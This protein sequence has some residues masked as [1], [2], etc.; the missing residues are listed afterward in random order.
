MPKPSCV[1]RSGLLTACAAVVAVFP[2]RA[3]PGGY[4]GITSDYVLRG[5]SQSDGKAAWQG[6]LHWDFPAGLT[7]GVWTSQV[8][9]EPHSESVELDGYLQWR[10]TLSPDFDFGAAATHYSYPGDPR[11]VNYNYDELSMSLTWRDQFSFSASWTPNVTLYSA[12]N[13][14][15][16]NRTAYTVEVGWHRDLPARL[17]VSAGVGFFWPPGL[18]YG[19]YAYG[20]ATVGWQYGHWRVNL[21]WIWVQ[22][23]AH[24]QYATG[25]AG[26]PLV[27]SVAWVF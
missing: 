25:P 15:A 26:G 8:E 6:D 19:S 18:D 7:A 3:G 21:A 20:D 13:G 17:N 14:L 10:R 24:R 12:A 11:P 27:A 1:I 4:I 9:F 2:A 22:D 16:A 5:V 23:A